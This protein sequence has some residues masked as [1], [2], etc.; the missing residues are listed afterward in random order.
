MR[1]AASQQAKQP[2]I[3]ATPIRLKAR[4][5]PL[6]VGAITATAMIVRVTQ[7]HQSLFGDEVLAY[8]DIVGHSLGAVIRT[9]RGG[10]ESSPPLFFVLAWLSAKLGD[11]TVWIRLPSL[12]LGVAAIPVTYILGSETIGRAGGVIGAAVLAASPFSIY[13]GIEGRPYATL[14]FFTALSTLALVRAVDGAGRR[15]WALYAVAAAAAMYTHYTAIFILVLQTA[16]SLWTCRDRLREPLLA[17]GAALVLY[18]PWLPEVHG[19]NLAVYSLLEPLT[20]HNVVEDLLRPIAGYPYA[21]LHQIPTVLGLIAIVACAA[22]GALTLARHAARRARLGEIAFS[23]QALI[24]WLALATPVGLLLYSMIST[25]IWDARD[26]YASVPAAALV[27]GGVLAATPRRLIIP[28]VAITLLVLTLGTIR[29]VSPTYARPQY[30]TVA[31]YLDRVATPGDP[32][33]MFTSVFNLDEA[34]PAQFHGRHLVIQGEPKRWP[35]IPHGGAVYVVVDDG[36]LRLLH[37]QDP[38]PRTYKLIAR[39]QYDGLVQFTL[40]TYGAAPGGHG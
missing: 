23:K 29:A 2:S 6:A 28:V 35:A 25:D 4:V 34:I 1:V 33:V 7:M 18:L 24:L 3:W 8:H 37:L 20:V 9:V 36:A 10:V 22:V 21:S 38:P 15:W 13:Y 26:L 19:S 12:L 32:V 40:A 17:S 31:A 14:A 5:A 16:W 11:P 27:L 39:R 30:R